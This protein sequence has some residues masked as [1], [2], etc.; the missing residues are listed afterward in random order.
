MTEIKPFTYR[1]NVSAA[2]IQ[3]RFNAL[4][5][6]ISDL[7]DTVTDIQKYFGGALVRNATLKEWTTAEAYQMTSITYDATYTRVVSEADIVW[8]D[9]SNGTFTTISINGAY[10][11]IDAY[12]VSHDLSG[13]TVSQ[14]FVTRNGNGD[15]TTRPELVVSS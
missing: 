12:Q 9:G 15:V 5:E 8:P 3:A 4:R 2:T 10:E 1:G 13:K 14:P 11:V 6:L 7:L